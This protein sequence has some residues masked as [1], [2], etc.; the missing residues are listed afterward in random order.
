MS[1]NLFNEDSYD[2]NQGQGLDLPSLDAAFVDERSTFEAVAMFVDMAGSTEMKL[3]AD[4]AAW[5]TRLGHLY[6]LIFDTAFSNEPMQMPHIKMIGDGAL[7]TWNTAHT[8][9]A[10]NAA[11]VIQDKLRLAN[12]APP[13]HQ[14]GDVSY[15]VSIGMASGPVKRFRLPDGGVDHVGP[16]VDLAARLCSAAAPQAIVMHNS[17][18]DDVVWRRVHSPEGLVDNRTPGQYRGDAQ[19]IF[20]KGRPE[21]QEFYELFWSRSAFGVTATAASV[22]TLTARSAAE[23]TGDSTRQHTKVTR[24]LGHKKPEELYGSIV[25]WNPTSG[26]GFVKVAA[27]GECF[28]FTPE[29]LC[30][31]ED[32]E[33]LST[34]KSLAF[35]AK[36]APEEG[37]S[38]E[39][40]AALIVD[41]EAEGKVHWIAP[42]RSHGFIWVEHPSGITKSVYLWMTD[43]LSWIQVGD[44]VGFDVE[45]TPRGLRAG[46]VA[47]LDDGDNNAA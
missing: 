14:A 40:M 4:T 24:I 7:L 37:K 32:A 1:A 21:A 19:Q 30:Y 27:S 28:H 18:A 38:R 20:V 31:P 13:G 39:A 23:G 33:H 11:I 47:R 9:V 26:H 22:S 43:S 44:E 10:V 34:D 35:V 12:M 17:T 8:T 45:L 6:K 46:N 5:V 25:K 3:F 15:Q 16:A 36:P 2:R 42:N 41:R 29:S